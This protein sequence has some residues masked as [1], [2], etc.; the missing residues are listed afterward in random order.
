MR[1]LL[2]LLP[3]FALSACVDGSVLPQGRGLITLECEIQTSPDPGS[4]PTTVE[5]SINEANGNASINLQK[6]PKAIQSSFS[7]E[8]VKLTLQE[9]GATGQAIRDRGTVFGGT[10]YS[11]G[12]GGQV[13]YLLT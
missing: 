4:Q 7:K 2:L 10:T 1:Q 6:G 11:G 13:L 9:M 12:W 8:K 3:L 5:F